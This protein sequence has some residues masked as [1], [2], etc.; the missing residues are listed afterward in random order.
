[1]SRTAGP[2][3]DR[4]QLDAAQAFAPIYGLQAA[5]AESMSAL[6]YSNC[7]CSHVCFDEIAQSAG[8]AQ[9]SFFFPPLQR[10]PGP[11]ATLPAAARLRIALTGWRLDVSAAVGY[12]S[13][14]FHP[15]RGES[16]APRTGN[17]D[18]SMPSVRY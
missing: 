7:P 3:A 4:Q 15:R 8:D 18:G 2:G 10:L 9:R 17:G 12:S 16:A 5:A 1:M 6:V 14:A 13:T 11:G